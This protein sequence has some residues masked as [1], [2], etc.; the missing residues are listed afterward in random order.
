MEYQVSDNESA[1]DQ[2][3]KVTQ[4][5]TIEIDGGVPWVYCE[6]CRPIED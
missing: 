5:A 3:G 4:Y 1:C 6:E 2:C